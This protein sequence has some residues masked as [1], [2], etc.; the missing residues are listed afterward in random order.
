[1]NRAH[2]EL[3]YWLKHS[4]IV[5]FTNNRTVIDFLKQNTSWHIFH[6]LF[7][8]CLAVLTSCF[9]SSIGINKKNSIS[10]VTCVSHN[11]YSISFTSY[12]DR[13]HPKVV[14]CQATANCNT[15]TCI[16]IGNFQRCWPVFAFNAK[17][18]TISG[19]SRE[20]SNSCIELSCR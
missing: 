18:T 8:C 17:R 3:V 14:N 13:G 4:K 16:K 2:I 9:I 7:E 11:K 12:H 20:N 5:F 6:Y 1:M 19:K 10:F 15:F